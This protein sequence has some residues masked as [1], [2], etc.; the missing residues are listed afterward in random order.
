M[1]REG[2][3][4]AGAVGRAA[5]ATARAAGM[6]SRSLATYQVLVALVGLAAVGTMFF[7]FATRP[8][9]TPLHWPLVEHWTEK[10]LLLLVLSG[11][12]SG[13]A[14]ALSGITRSM[15]RELLSSARA[16][17]R[18]GMP[19]GVLLGVASGLFFYLGLAIYL[20]IASVQESVSRS[21]LIVLFTAAL[22]MGGFAGVSWFTWHNLPLAQEILLLG[23]NVVFLSMLAGWFIGDIFRPLWV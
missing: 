8:I 20:V 15:E 2:A 12:V 14:F 1:A 5:A 7:Y 13:Y 21:V 11:W 22:L 19:V 16:S 10:V 9:G 18:P 23:G 6:R 17:G 3:P 4:A